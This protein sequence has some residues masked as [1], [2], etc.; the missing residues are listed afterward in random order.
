MVLLMTGSASGFFQVIASRNCFFSLVSN[1][2]S[3]ALN[4]CFK[5]SSK[6]LKSSL[7][8]LL[9]NANSNHYLSQCGALITRSVLDITQ[10]LLF[11]N[12]N[13]VKSF[14]KIYKRANIY[15]YVPFGS[16]CE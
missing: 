10:F 15:T 2:I 11:V 7:C 9:R 6:I 4:A 16:F 13:S 8:A 14:Q 1:L 3:V 5:V 12:S